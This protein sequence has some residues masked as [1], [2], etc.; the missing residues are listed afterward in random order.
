MMVKNKKSPYISL[1]LTIL[2][3]FTQPLMA[4]VYDLGSVNKR[5]IGKNTMHTVVKGDYFQQLAEQYNVGFLALLAANPQHDPFLLKIGAQLVIPSEMLLP[6]ITRQGIVINLPELRLYYF[7]PQENKVHVFPVGIGRQGLSTP[8]TSTVI[9]EKRKDP[10]W[11]PTQAMQERHFAEHGKYLAKEVPAGPNNPFGKYALRLGTSEYLIHGSNQRFGIG[12]RASSGC[13]RMY[14]DDIKW[15]FD[16]VP[17]NT[18]VRVINQP[19]KMSYENGEKQLI[20]I[21]QPLTDLDVTKNNVILTK[22]MHRFV[23]STREYWQQLLP[24][25]EKPHGLVVELAK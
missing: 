22:A 19:V 11:R 7:S 17:L 21:H 14:D 1:S 3:L 6:F 4:T 9:G 10:I 16:N 15:L 8:L 20:E 24:I 25:I 13:I 2:L 12:M 5:L 23:G 18:K